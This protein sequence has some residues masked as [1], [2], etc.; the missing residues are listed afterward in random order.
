[1]ANYPKIVYTAVSTPIT[2]TFVRGPSDFTPYWDGRVHDN[3]ASS[4]AARER[5][6]ENLDILIEF[7]MP[8]LVA[9]DD[10][11]GWAS[12]MGWA[13]LGGSFKFYPNSGMSDY[14]N[15]VEESG[16]MKLKHNAPKK[17]SAGF[18]FRVLQ[19]GQ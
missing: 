15:C 7:A 4:G 9:D 12:F 14:Y 2:L 18:T 19:D 13:L 10:M 11:P 6:T 16:G 5:V 8:H 1:M 17:Y 3:L